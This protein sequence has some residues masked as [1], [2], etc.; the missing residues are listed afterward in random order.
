MCRD[1]ELVT[2]VCA[3]TV[4]IAAELASFSPDYIAVDPPELIGGD[5]S[6]TTANP[7]IVSNTVDAVKAVNPAIKVLCGAG[8]KNGKDVATACELGASGVLLASGVVKSKD[9]ESVIR[10]G[11]QETVRFQHDAAVN[12][13][14]SGGALVNTS[15][16]LVG[17]NTLNIF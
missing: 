14:N 12:P 15:G 4:D 6:V 11:V 9:P 7:E 10:Q 17:I 1:L 13:G 3:D 8:V 2:C 16:E 5:I